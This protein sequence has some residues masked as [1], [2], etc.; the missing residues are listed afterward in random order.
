MKTHSLF[1]ISGLR[2]HPDIEA[3]LAPL[4]AGLKRAQVSLAEAQIVKARSY[5]EPQV[6]IHLTD[7]GTDTFSTFTDNPVKAAGYALLGLALGM[8]LVLGLLAM[9]LH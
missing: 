6:M 5:R 7:G 1:G 9:N 8:N 2:H 3:G 4:R